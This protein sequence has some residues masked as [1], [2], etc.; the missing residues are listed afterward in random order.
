MIKIE[1]KNREELKAFIRLSQE[2]IIE[3]ESLILNEDDSFKSFDYSAQK[4]LLEEILPKVERKQFNQQKTNSISINKA[5]AIV[6]FKH[7]EIVVDV[8]A[9][10]LKNLLVEKIYRE[11]V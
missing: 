10:M 2:I 7:R 3:L 6:I 11:M 4:E 1:F 5:T 8:Y 9:E